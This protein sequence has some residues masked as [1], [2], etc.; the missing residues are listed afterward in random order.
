MSQGA[1]NV[2]RVFVKP[3]IYYELLCMFW[4]NPVIN[5]VFIEIKFVTDHY[6]NKLL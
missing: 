6:E 2:L 3:V 5:D 4:S 1:S